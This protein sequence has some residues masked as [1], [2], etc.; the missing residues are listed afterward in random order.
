MRQDYQSRPTK[1]YDFKQNTM[2][3]NFSYLCQIPVTEFRM[4]YALLFFSLKVGGNRK[5]AYI[6]K[7]FVIYGLE[8]AHSFKYL[9]I[10]LTK[11]MTKDVKFIKGIA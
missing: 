9:W 8:S 4:R 11:Y 10:V 5:R 3:L 2:D 1:N 7:L 6:L